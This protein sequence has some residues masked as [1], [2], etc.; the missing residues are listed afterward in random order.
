[1]KVRYAWFPHPWLSLLLLLVWLLLNDSLAPG[2]ILLG[3]VLGVLIPLFSKRFWPQTPELR[4]PLSALRLAGLVLYDIVVANFVVA[5][6]VLGPSSAVKP[7][8]VRVPL[9]VTGDFAITL[10]AS[11]VS[12]TPGTVSAELDTRRRYLLVH[13][14]SEE[15]PDALVHRIKS[16]YEIP[17]KEILAC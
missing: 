9:D 3:A 15:D 11:V 10:L 1:M 8:F 2:Q 17:V 12:L 4:R 7:A 13:A 14:L 5:R 16:R 6:I